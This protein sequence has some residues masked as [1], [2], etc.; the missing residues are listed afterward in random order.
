[1]PRSGK[2]LPTVEADFTAKFPEFIDGST[3]AALW[4]KGTDW[5]PA[6]AYGVTMHGFRKIVSNQKAIYD[7]IANIDGAANALRAQQ[8]AQ[9]AERMASLCAE[10]ASRAGT[11]QEITAAAAPV[12]EELKAIRLEL[13]QLKQK[14]DQKPVATCN[15]VVS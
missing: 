10:S 6:H 7:S 2:P 15:C 13:E 8:A 5:D 3:G 12:L 9:E 11:A 1:M 14:V 4:S